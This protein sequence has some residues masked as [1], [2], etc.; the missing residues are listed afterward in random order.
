M[1][2][3]PA[4]LISGCSICGG[5]TMI[6]SDG[7]STLMSSLKAPADLNLFAHSLDEALRAINSDYDAKRYKDITLQELEIVVARPALFDDWLRSR[8]KLGGQHKVPRL[9]NHRDL[10]EEILAMNV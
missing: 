9:S 7:L 10:I 8:G 6:F 5:E 1:I 2:L 4:T 3:R